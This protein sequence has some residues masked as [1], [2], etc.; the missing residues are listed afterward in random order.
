MPSHG[1]IIIVCTA[2]ICRSPMG[3]GL[4]RHALSGQPEPLRSLKVI[5]AGVMARRGDEVSENSVLA[6]RKVGIDLSGHQAQPL[7]Q[8]MLDEARAIFCMTEGHRSMIA[9]Q[10]DPVPAH[11]HLFRE[12]MPS[13]A[14]KEI[15]DPYGGSLRL[16]EQCRDELVEAIPGLLEYLRTLTAKA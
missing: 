5:S 16:Y 7:T 4:L 10:A 13:P 6:L 8:K 12:F 14:A 2:N 9:L 11:L 3:E 15:G 1:P